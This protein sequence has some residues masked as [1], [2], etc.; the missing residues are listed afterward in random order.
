MAKE[1]RFDVSFVSPVRL[2]G[3]QIETVYDFLHTFLDLFVGNIYESK[4]QL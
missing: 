4:E 1:I 2:T 3:E